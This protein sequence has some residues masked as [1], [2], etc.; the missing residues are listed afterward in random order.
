MERLC[1]E[2]TITRG[3]VTQDEAFDAFAGT[4]IALLFPFAPS[5]GVSVCESLFE[6]P[7][8]MKHTSPLIRL[9]DMLTPSESPDE[10]STHSD[11][12]LEDVMGGN[13]W[14]SSPSGFESVHSGSLSMSDK[15]S[16]QSPL[17]YQQFEGIY[18]FIEQCDATR[19]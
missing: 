9:D 17:E 11:S 3:T 13:P 10:Y 18:R 8:P 12:G 14:L 6:E 1:D 15:H 16:P 4:E 5:N 2:L 19:R 7:A